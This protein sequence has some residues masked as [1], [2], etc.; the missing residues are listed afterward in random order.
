[1]K[2]AL[3]ALVALFCVS[4]LALGSLLD[5]LE[6]R[7]SQDVQYLQALKSLNQAQQRLRKDKNWF[8]PYLDL[9]AEV[10][11]VDEELLVQAQPRFS[12]DVSGW[13]IYISNSLSVNSKSAD[14]NGW[15]FELSKD[16]F[17]SEK[18]EDLEDQASYLEALWSV[19]NNRNRVFKNLVS[20]IF[21]SWIAR[22][23]LQLMR[24]ELEIRQ[25]IYE[26]EVHRTGVTVSEEELDTA[27][28]N[29]LSL[30]GGLED[31]ERQLL[32]KVE[33][34]EPLLEET[35]KVL[36][37]LVGTQTGKDLQRED[38]RALEMRLKAAEEE[39]NRSFL[40]YLPSP[41]LSIKWLENP[42]SGQGEFS[43]GI[44]L[45]WSLLDRGEKATTV[46]AI[47]LDYRIALA[48]YQ[49]TRDD[50]KDQLQSLRMALESLEISRQ[51]AE[52]DLKMAQTDLD[53]VRRQFERGLITENELRLT[54]IEVM[55]R[56]LDVKQIHFNTLVTQLEL[57]ILQGVDLVALLEVER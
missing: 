39:K 20:E 52:I 19:K 44:S 38:I 1:M 47:N 15:N 56:E 35:V 28:K 42:A 51:M 55:E 49:K 2:R 13:S 8:I 27:R 53:R 21:D 5:L 37:S 46:Q 57:Q 17:Q 45:D 54:E 40:R 9:S 11:F 7:L 25:R 50:L 12:F 16:L 29:L 43:V 18:I 34:D 31:L 14:W 36:E 22:Q 26:E 10:V 30:E 4:T 48:N 32:G 3:S 6:E 33:V 41:S 23:K 24:E